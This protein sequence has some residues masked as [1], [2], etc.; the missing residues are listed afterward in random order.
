MSVAVA[1]IQDA[2][3]ASRTSSNGVSAGALTDPGGRRARTDVP[4]ARVPDLD[5]RWQTIERRHLDALLTVAAEG[6]FRRAAERLGYVQAAISG[7][8]AQ[9][10]RAAG[11]RLVERTSGSPIVT[12]T[13]AGLLLLRHAEE[14]IA[15]FDAACSD[16]G[17]LGHR[18][19]NVVRIAGLERLGPDT[20]ARVL[21]LL[22]NRQPFTR[23][24]VENPETVDPVNDRHTPFDLEIRE[25]PVRVGWIVQAVVV[26]D[27][28]SLLVRADSAL[29]ERPLSRR[30]VARLRPIVPRCCE[31]GGLGAQLRRL[32]IASSRAVGF[33][34]ASAVQALVGEG[35]GA[36][37]VPSRLVDRSDALTVAIDLSHLLHP[38]TL[39]LALDPECEYSRAAHGLIRAVRDV[40]GASYDT[41]HGPVSGYGH[42]GGS[43]PRAA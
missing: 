37:I 31:S 17:S 22:R 38:Q 36:A 42:T 26:H 40:C 34:S 2:S 43:Q 23:V 41:Q 8:I 21:T 25:P 4:Y 5:S 16:L 7:Q 39:V 27:Q 24:S 9:L 20:F 28:Y 18:G 35:L 13:P 33:D 1:E 10:E 29:L 32:G 12:L 6:S 15:R 14:I 30:A 11:M 3:P 19:T